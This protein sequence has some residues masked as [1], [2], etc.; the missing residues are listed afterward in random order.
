MERERSDSCGDTLQHPQLGRSPHAFQRLPKQEGH[1]KATRERGGAA[2]RA[3]WA[4]ELPGQVSGGP[5]RQGCTPE[6]CISCSAASASCP[7]P[8]RVW[9][10]GGNAQDCNLGPPAPQ[11]RA[12]QDGGIGGT[13]SSTANRSSGPHP[14]RGVMSWIYRKGNT[15]QSA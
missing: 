3:A 15:I 13:T 2:T 10:L 7:G 6:L 1:G 8:V 14:S 9:G 5:G 11:Q 12:S 4:L